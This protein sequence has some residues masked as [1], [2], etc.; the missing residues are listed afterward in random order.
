MNKGRE[1]M[2]ARLQ[3]MHDAIRLVELLSSER[4]PFDRLHDLTREVGWWR[5]PEKDMRKQLRLALAWVRRQAR[6]L[7]VEVQRHDT[8]EHPERRYRTWNCM[9]MP[10]EDLPGYKDGVAAARREARKKQ[11]AEDLATIAGAAIAEF[12]ALE[13]GG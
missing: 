5:A 12:D 9:M 2:A 1:L 4:K 6:H 10:R 13:G 8:P 7:F 3:G 11:G